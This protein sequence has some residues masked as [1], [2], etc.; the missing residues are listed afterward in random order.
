MSACLYRRDCAK[1]KRSLFLF[2]KFSVF[3]VG[4]DWRFAV[5]CAH[6]RSCRPTHSSQ[7]TPPAPSCCFC[8]SCSCFCLDS[9][10]SCSSS[11]F[12]PLR[13]CASLLLLFSCRSSSVSSPLFSFSTTSSLQYPPP[14]YFSTTISSTFFLPLRLVFFL[15]VLLFAFLSFPSFPPPLPPSLP[16]SPILLP[17]LLQ[18]LLRHRLLV[19]GFYFLFTSVFSCSPPSSSGSYTPNAMCHT[20]YLIC[21]CCSH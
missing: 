1:V 10:S 6:R 14:S 8:C 4:L 20:Q 17:L 9:S 5:C 2:R 7:H 16:R 11:P 19:P 18:L 3:G 13:P 21:A 12:Y 15:F